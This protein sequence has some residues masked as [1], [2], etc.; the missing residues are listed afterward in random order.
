MQKDLLQT[1]AIIVAIFMA[2]WAIRGD[3]AENSSA[4]AELRG[5]LLAHVGGHSHVRNVIA[6]TGAANA[7][8][9]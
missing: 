6:E 8:E 2:A 7:E 1:A 4:I 5:A 9:Q 3:I